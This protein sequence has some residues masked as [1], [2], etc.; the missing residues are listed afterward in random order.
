M[1]PYRR[2]MALGF[3]TQALMTS[4]SPN[5]PAPP[6][7]PQ[8]DHREVRHGATVVDPYYWLREK[9]SPKVIQYLEAEN[10]YTEAITKGIQSFSQT[11]YTE[12]LGRIKQTDLSV[13]VRRG[14]NFYYSRT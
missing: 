10:A 14:K 1:Q 6:V 8:V 11:L 2:A 3:L 7:A 4:Q 9:S 12:M 5:I 13:A